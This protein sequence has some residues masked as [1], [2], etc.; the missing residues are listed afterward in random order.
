MTHVTQGLY[1]YVEEVQH[2]STFK[3]L[4]GYDGRH[5]SERFARLAAAAFLQHGAY[6]Y[7]FSGAAVWQC[8]GGWLTRAEMCPTPYVAYGIKKLGC[9]VGIMVT[10][11]H[12]PKARVSVWTMSFIEP[13][14]TGGQR[15]QGVLEQRRADQLAPRQGDRRPDR[16]ELDPVVCDVRWHSLPAHT[17]VLQG[18]CMERPAVGRSP[19]LWRSA[20]CRGRQLPARHC[21]AQAPGLGGTARRGQDDIHGDARY[22]AMG[23][24]V[25]L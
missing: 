19:Q 20:G 13:L 14:L 3:V 10:A 4:I 9:A 8:V 25:T 6:V 7:L 24:R 2:G 1:K 15:V 12:N 22:G 17:R 21:A 11:S 5:N 23:S 18:A 16:Q